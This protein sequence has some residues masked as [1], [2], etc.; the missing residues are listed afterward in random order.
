MRWS[1]TTC[2]PSART[3]SRL[4]AVPAPRAHHAQLLRSQAEEFFLPRFP[5][6]DDAI[7]RPPCALHAWDGAGEVKPFQEAGT[8][9][10]EV[11]C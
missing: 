9:I 2:G 10:I 6:R 5:E 7:R 11:V 4:G 8:R 1:P 3:S